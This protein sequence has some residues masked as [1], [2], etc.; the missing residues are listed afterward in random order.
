MH[1]QYEARRR[2]RHGHESYI[3][4]GG[5]DSRQYVII[6]IRIRKRN[7]KNNINK[8]YN[9]TLLEV[10]LERLPKLVEDKYRLFK[11]KL[12]HNLCHCDR[13]GSERNHSRQ[14]YKKII[15][16]PRRQH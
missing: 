8:P 5:L 2:N 10:Q 14:G 3:R 9:H 15:I 6:K 12:P 13:G 1:H 11:R 16:I 7:Q 4:E